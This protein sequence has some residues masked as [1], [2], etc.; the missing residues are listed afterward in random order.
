MQLGPKLPLGASDKIRKHQGIAVAG[1][2]YSAFY[3]VR[4]HQAEVG[5]IFARLRSSGDDR[6]RGHR[7]SGNGSWYRGGTGHR[8]GV[9]RGANPT[10][11]GNDVAR[12]IAISSRLRAGGTIVAT[13][14]QSRIIAGIL[15]ARHSATKT[16]TWGKA[17]VTACQAGEP[18]LAASGAHRKK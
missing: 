18:S 7:C 1:E 11:I 4:S 9:S 16:A 17:C 14:H 2:P 8:W 15:G 12:V 6:F 10:A 5:G 3:Q 13:G